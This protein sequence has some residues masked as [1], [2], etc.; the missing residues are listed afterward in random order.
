MRTIAKA[1]SRCLFNRGKTK[2][3]NTM[4]QSTTIPKGQENLIPKRARNGAST[5]P[6]PRAPRGVGMLP[7]KRATTAFTIKHVIR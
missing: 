2:G 4:N 3:T 6:L 7:L 1:V 5:D